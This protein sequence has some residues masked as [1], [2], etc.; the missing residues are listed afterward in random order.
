M[1]FKV[2]LFIEMHPFNEYVRAHLLK[3][4]AGLASNGTKDLQNTVNTAP[5][6]NYNLSFHFQYLCTKGCC[7]HN[8]AVRPTDK[9]TTDNVGAGNT[10]FLFQTPDT[11][12]PCAHVDCVKSRNKASDGSQT[13]LIFYT[14]LHNVSNQA[15]QKPK[16]KCPPIKLTF[17]TPRIIL[18]DIPVWSW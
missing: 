18:N 15:H 3:W 5:Q 8:C 17:Q 9:R 10:R 6:H 11:A 16:E 14:Q 4:S 7:E 13:L 2:L 1:Y 12:S